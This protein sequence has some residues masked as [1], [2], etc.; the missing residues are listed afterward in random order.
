MQIF[1]IHSTINISRLR[2]NCRVAT[3]LEI[4]TGRRMLRQLQWLPATCQ[5]RCRMCRTTYYNYSFCT[6]TIQF[7]IVTFL[8]LLLFW[9]PLE[10]QTFSHS[11]LSFLR[12]GSTLAGKPV[13][14]YVKK[15][16]SYLLI[17][18]EWSETTPM[19]RKQ[20][21]FT[22]LKL[23]STLNLLLPDAL[24]KKVRNHCHNFN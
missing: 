15:I 9:Y 23:R 11:N 7:C 14:I 19:F 5:I 6:T 4:S 17:S 24:L 1:T 18:L 3:T 16:W 13:F 2:T 21:R 10:S 20:W 8:L 22:C 12:M